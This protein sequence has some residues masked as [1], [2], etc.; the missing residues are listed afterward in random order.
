MGS[1]PPPLDAVWVRCTGL[2]GLAM[3]PESEASTL[4]DS[5]LPAAYVAADEASIRWQ[6]RA[7]SFLRLQLLCG[8]AGAATGL[9]SWRWRDT[10]VDLLAALGVAGFFAALYFSARLADGSA[11]RRW[12]GARAAAESLRT[13]AWRYAVRAEPF[14]HVDGDAAEREFIRRSRDVLEHLHALD[15]AL[16]PGEGDQITAPMQSVRAAN[17]DSRRDVYRRGRVEDQI[18]WYRDK[19]QSHS[20]SQ[21]QWARATILANGL[22]I[23]AGLSRFL[24]LIDIDVLG[25]FAAAAG[26][27]TAW[28]QA[29][30]HGS[31]VAAYS[32]AEHELRLVSALLPRITSEAQWAEFVA[33]AE[34]AISREHTMWLASRV[35][36]TMARDDQRG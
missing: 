18:E 14:G 3:I 12:Y 5:S 4:D 34:E 28:S 21:R 7:M 36:R 13:L 10:D 30:Q 35:A 16:R 11:L 25:L 32:L 6:K 23:A 15:V 22:A 26:S 2:R 17:L 19:A 9:A 27:A 33:D 8:L 29:R 1:T 24:G 20:R 31:L